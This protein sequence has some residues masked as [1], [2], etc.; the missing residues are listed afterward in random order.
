MKGGE[1]R[2]TDIPYSDSLC[3]TERENIRDI[4]HTIDVTLAVESEGVPLCGTRIPRIHHESPNVF[5]P[6]ER[7]E[8]NGA[9]ESLTWPELVA[10][11]RNALPGVDPPDDGLNL[12]A[13]H[14][15]FGINVGQHTRDAEAL[16]KVHEDD[17]DGALL[18]E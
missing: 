3:S 5:L 18:F 4:D 11:S 6:T 8:A 2:R 13:C 17:A 7:K 12:V 1:R 10:V 16:L 9:G 15:V 14:D